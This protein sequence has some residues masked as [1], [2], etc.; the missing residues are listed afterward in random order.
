MSDRDLFLRISW[1]RAN[2]HEARRRRGDRAGA[3]LPRGS[4]RFVVGVAVAAAAGTATFL[5]MVQGSLRKGYTDLDFNHTLGTAVEGHDAAR[6]AG[7][8]APSGWSAT[9]PAR[10]G[11]TPALIGAVRP[12]WP[13]T[14]S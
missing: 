14:R 5:I 1:L 9:R 8:G 3:A 12:R 2:P 11:S 13:S 10:S 4:A 6:D 7:P